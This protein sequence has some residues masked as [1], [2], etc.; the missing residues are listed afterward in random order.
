MENTPKISVIVPIYNVD[1]YLRK[2]LDSLKCQ[3]LK[4]IEILC[5]D[6]G[7]TDC[8][9]EIA[10]EYKKD[11]RFRIF[12]TENNG[13]SA[14][15]N[16]GIDKARAEWLMF[17]DSDDWVSEEFC[18][19]PYK[20]AIENHADLVIFGIYTFWDSDKI[21]KK[22]SPRPYGIID[23]Y[24][25]HEFCGSA[26]W[27]RIYQKR[28]FDTIRYP[29][30]RTFE[31]VATTHK[32]VHIADRI[33]SIPDCLY[34]HRYRNDSISHT[35]TIKNIKDLFT[36]E[37]ERYEDLLSYGFPE[38]KIPICRDALRFLIKVPPNDDNL[39]V[40]AQGILDSTKGFPMSLSIKLKIALAAWKIDNRLFYFLCKAM[41]T[42]KKS[43]Y[44]L[45]KGD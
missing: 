32:I 31:D 25:A 19:I 14:A 3:T 22:E 21:P 41:R 43:P 8:S 29:L 39:S 7:S 42:I 23:E 28:L 18:S 24:T 6:D 20:A 33:M 38:E 44:S 35:Y 26:A 30:K 45:S 9:G 27:R 40:K 12:H 5:I 15:R 37:I 36:S 34:Y 13:L 2:C 10:D 4:E 11:T 17:V 16:L 1:K